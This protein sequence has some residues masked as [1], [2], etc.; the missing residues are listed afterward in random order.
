VTRPL[1]SASWY[2]VA[3]LRPR[4]RRHALVH[5]QSYRGQTW[6]VLQDRAGEQFHRLSPPAYLVVGLM[7]GRRTVQEI[8]DVASTRLGDDAPTQDEVIQLLS[9]LHAADLLQSEAPPHG[10]ELGE[11]GARAERRRLLARLGSLVSWRVPLLDP[12]RLLRALAPA[13]SPLW[14]R[15]GAALWLAVVAPAAVLLAAHWTDF[16]HGVV[17]RALAP[18]NLAL[19]WLL[20]PVIKALHELGHATATK[21]FGGEVHDMGVMLILL[22]PVPYVDATAAWAFPDRWARAAVGAAGMLVELLIAAGALYVW[23]AAEPGLVRALA[24]DAILVAGI[25]T[26]LFNANPLLRF[27]G[28]YILCDVLELPN[29]R[30]RAGA[31]WRYL[32]ERRLFGRRDAEPPVATAGERA[33]FVLYAAGAAAY[34]VLVLAAIVLLVIGWSFWLGALLAA[35]GAVAWGLVPL[36]RGVVFLVSSPRLRTVRARALLVTATAVAA[37]AWLVV[38]WPAPYRTRA[39]G[40]IWVPDEANVRAGADG[41]VERVVA[42]P[43]AR[44]RA[45]DVLLVLGDPAVGARIR[46]LEARRREILARLDEQRHGDLVRAG[47]LREELVYVEQSVAEARA[48]AAE[49]TVR[50]RAAGAFVVPSPEDLPG[51]FVRKGELIGYAVELDRVTVRAVVPQE[52]VELVRH[53]MAGVDVRLAEQL[54][55]VVPGAIWRAV[56][57][58]S[59]RLPAPA[60]GTEGGGQVAIDPRDRQGLTAMTRHFQVDIE[61]PTASRRL[62]V[63]GRAYVRFDHGREPLAAQWYAHVRRLF[64]ARFNV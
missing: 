21:A 53:R 45:G 20:F 38:V 42:A 23:L 51:R 52:A 64:L 11:R 37:I 6:H 36:G 5:R 12:E 9:Q 30:A 3:E 43:G 27:D 60:L 47:M 56:P 31:Y 46:E 34:R 17:D 33:W 13:V 22:T 57:G 10:A 25:S 14:S 24:F 29:L 44:V 55:V 15:W 16:T 18:A 40:V 7:D 59:E 4:L 35:A 63:G 8:W 28:Y 49:L 41:F 19:L 48:R 61:L 26:V 54:D 50:S 32:C 2:R 1:F 58:G 39:E 62:N